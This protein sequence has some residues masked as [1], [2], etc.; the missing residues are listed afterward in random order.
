MVLWTGASRYYHDETAYVLKAPGLSKSGI[1]WLVRRQVKAVC[2]DSPSP[3]HIFMRARR[4]VELRKDVFGDVDID[5]ASFPPSYGHK[6]FMA[7]GIMMVESLSEAVES[8]VGQRFTLM[9]LPAKYAGVE[10]AP[11]RVVAITEYP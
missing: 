2:S 10:G 4:W 7:H 8:L 5:R 6:T 9:A 3:E 11:A 1:D